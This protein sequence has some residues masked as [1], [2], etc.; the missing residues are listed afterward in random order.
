MNIE[1]FAL[2]KF[3][4]FEGRLKWFH[5]SDVFVSKIEKGL[6]C[7]TLTYDVK[8]NTAKI[9]NVFDPENPTVCT[10]AELADTLKKMGLYEERP[11][12]ERHSS[13]FVPMPVKL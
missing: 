4:E 7:Y 13:S 11:E 9:A 5:A 1:T 12:T 6:E 2:W 10:F 8:T 3:K